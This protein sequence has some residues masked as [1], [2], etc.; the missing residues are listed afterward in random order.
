MGHHYAVK[1]NKWR[2]YHFDLN[3]NITADKIFEIEN[4]IDHIG[5]QLWNK[6]VDSARWGKYKYSYPIKNKKTL[7]NTLLTK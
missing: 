6:Y 2:D 7:I 3:P 4:K 5:N 1:Q